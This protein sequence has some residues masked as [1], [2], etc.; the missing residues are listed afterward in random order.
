VKFVFKVDYLVGQDY[1]SDPTKLT[2]SYLY[3]NFDALSNNFQPVFSLS[4]TLLN[5]CQYPNNYCYYSYG[6]GGGSGGTFTFDSLSDTSIRVSF[7]PVSYLDFQGYT[8]YN[9]YFRLQFHG[10]G[11]GAGCSISNVVAEITNSATPA[12]GS[13]WNNTLDFDTQSCNDNWI[14][15]FWT[16]DRMFSE[17]WGRVGLA[18]N[19]TWN[20]TFY[21]ILYIIVVPGST[22][23]L[24]VM[25][26]DYIFMSG[27]YNY[28]YSSNS[29]TDQVRN[30]A[31]LPIQTLATSASVT[32]LTDTREAVTELIMEVKSLRVNIGSA[33][34]NYLL[35][36]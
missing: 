19:N 25:D 12:P 20:T 21:I 4:S 1:N 26:H 15:I 16:T 27:T 22:Q 3:A 14:D 11:F 18:E 31:W 28:Q 35:L 29:W 36:A 7:K 5:N 9:H 2:Y 23:D 8:V 6:A 34:N 17:N 24:P 10:F 32:T 33:N 13:G 30:N